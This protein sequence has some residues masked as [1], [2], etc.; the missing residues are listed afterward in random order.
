MSLHGDATDSLWLATNQDL[1]DFPL[2]QQDAWLRRF[3]LLSYSDSDDDDDD[4]MAVRPVAALPQKMPRYNPSKLELLKFRITN[5]LQSEEALRQKR[6][7][8]AEARCECAELQVDFRQRHCSFLSFAQTTP[9]PKRD[10]VTEFAALLDLNSD[11][12]RGEAL[13]EQK[14]TALDEWDSLQCQMTPL[15]HYTRLDEIV[16]SD[17]SRFSPMPRR[18]ATSLLRRVNCTAVLLAVA[19]GDLSMITVADDQWY[20]F[21]LKSP[22][23]GATVSHIVMRHEFL[24]LSTD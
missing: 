8:L 14:Q 17:W 10:Y 24:F 20:I 12:D 5:L 2:A 7:E 1:H 15:S 4:C 13:L 18:Q 19:R 16:Q 6:S 23:S 21:I 9:L 22:Q 3:D 11:L